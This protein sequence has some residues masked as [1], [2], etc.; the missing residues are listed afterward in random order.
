MS[1][2]S[3]LRYS[4][5]VPFHRNRR[6]LERCLAA[7]APP[8]AA[9]ELIV[10]ADGAVDPCGDIAARFGASVVDLPRSGGPA[11]A[12]NRGAEVARGRLLVFVDADVV[13]CPGAIDGLCRAIEDGAGVDGVFGAYDEAPEAPQFISQYRNLAH[14]Y[15]HQRSAERATTF[16]AGLGAVRAE[17]FQAVGGFDE[18][19]RR[20]CV[21]DIEL[22]YRLTEAGYRIR[23][24]H[25]LRGTHLKR[26]TLRSSIVS[27]VR[28][29][30]IPWTQLLARYARRDNDLN[31]RVEDRLSVVLAYAFVLLA[32]CAPLWR[33]LAA[34][35][36]AAL[37]GFL[38]LNRGYYGYFTR[39]RGPLFAL[40]IVPFHLLHHLCNGLSYVIGRATLVLSPRLPQPLPW[41]VPLEPWRG[42]ALRGPE[43]TASAMARPTA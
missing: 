7:L 23:L 29:R 32:V 18:R 22:G 15:V 34:G 37:A 11:A 17:A 25:R 28:D 5:V 26:W 27:D 21:E 42:R 36:L 40:R 30:G 16:W 3:D 33:P 9:G 41:A 19:F 24:D 2:G 20:P 35:S 13:A 12:R 39:R 38:L 10:V 1:G 4:I 14:S 43:S 8:D 31:V 6:Q